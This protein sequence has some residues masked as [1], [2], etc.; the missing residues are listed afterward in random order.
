MLNRVAPV[1]VRQLVGLDHDRGF[2]MQEMSSS[3]QMKMGSGMVTGSPS[4]QGMGS[5]DMQMGGISPAAPSTAL[6][7]SVSLVHHF[8]SET[9]ESDVHC[10]MQLQNISLARSELV[11]EVT[12]IRR[13]KR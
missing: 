3:M 9:V 1:D 2:N 11:R 7:P 5:P 4:M 6:T 13:V 12:S 8:I 10:N